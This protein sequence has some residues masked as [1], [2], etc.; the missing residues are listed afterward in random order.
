[1]YRL[2]QS[3]ERIVPR[4]VTQKLKE[5]LQAHNRN[6]YYKMIDY[7]ASLSGQAPLDAIKGPSD[8]SLINQ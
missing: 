3:E 2:D 7:L 6:I 1:M 5:T 8:P 4:K